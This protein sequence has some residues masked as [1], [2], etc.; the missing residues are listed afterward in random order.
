MIPA[1]MRPKFV[2]RVALPAEEVL[3]RMDHFFA[4]GSRKI[5]G[6]VLGRHMYLTVPRER[7]RFW[8]PTLDVDVLPDERGCELR[9]YFG[10]LPNVW[11]MFL[12][13]YAVL[14]LV[15]GAALLIACSQFI[16]GQS[17]SALLALPL[18]ILLA[19]LLYLASLSGQKISADQIREIRTALDAQLAGTNQ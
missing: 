4:H 6:R 7:Q 16:L 11:T 5:R 8:S 10:P 17:P 3:Q 15:G 1:A 13:M 2:I 9:G 14:I 12:A 19:G 18:C